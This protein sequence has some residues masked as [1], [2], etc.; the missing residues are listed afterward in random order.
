MLDSTRSPRTQNHRSSGPMLW[1]MLANRRNGGSPAQDDQNKRPVIP[2]RDGSPPELPSGIFDGP[3]LVKRITDNPAFEKICD[4][5]A[6]NPAAQR[7]LMSPNAQAL[8]YCLVR[9]LK[10]QHV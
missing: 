2:V 6:D 9:V 10:P 5:F 3:E 8:I 4:F 1:Q 7:S